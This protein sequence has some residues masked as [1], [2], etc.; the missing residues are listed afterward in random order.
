MNGLLAWWGIPGAEGCAIDAR[1]RRTLALVG[2]LN[3]VL[4]EASSRQSEALCAANDEYIRALQAMLKARQPAELIT[5]QSSIVSAFMECFA[6][7]TKAWAELAQKL[8]ANG[9][10]GTSE[11]AIQASEDVAETMR[12]LSQTDPERAPVL[13]TGRSAAQA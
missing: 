6:A 2:H 9:S 8:C 12:L 4:R 7:Q 10:A 3:E 5:A 1:T 13:G 11:K